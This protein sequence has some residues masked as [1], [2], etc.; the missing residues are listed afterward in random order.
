MSDDPRRKYEYV[1]D[2]IIPGASILTGKS[3]AM[4]LINKLGLPEGWKF[5]DRWSEEADE[6]FIKVSRKE[7]GLK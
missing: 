6:T 2:E 1:D 3:F 4:M 5:W 7:K